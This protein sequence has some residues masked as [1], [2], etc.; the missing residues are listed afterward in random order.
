M[1]GAYD[2]L[3]LLSVVHFKY[4]LSKFV[5]TSIAVQ[6]LSLIELIIYIPLHE[7][8]YLLRNVPSFLH[9]LNYRYLVFVNYE[10]TDIFVTER[11]S[12]ASRMRV[13]SDV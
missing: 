5:Q 12:P 7:K 4:N 11:T 3:I 2:I 9:I 1:L 10:L 8:G 6:E 13:V